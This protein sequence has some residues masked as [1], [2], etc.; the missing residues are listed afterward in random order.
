MAGSDGRQRWQAAV[1]G[2]GLT[3]GAV[4]LPAQA[5]RTHDA[6]SEVSTQWPLRRRQEQAT[7]V[8]ANSH[9]DIW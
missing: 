1:A 7:H 8:K 5:G 6:P 9:T 3:P 4:A 2:S